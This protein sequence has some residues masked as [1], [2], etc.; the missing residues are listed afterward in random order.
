[1]EHRDADSMYSKGA[2]FVS[3]WGVEYCDVYMYVCVT[4]LYCTQ[5]QKL[6]ISPVALR[7][8]CSAVKKYK[9]RSIG[10]YA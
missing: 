10:L 9:T 3:G 8:C 4:V 5:K 2:I 6:R 1:M 7:L